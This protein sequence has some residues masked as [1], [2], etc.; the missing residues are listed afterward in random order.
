MTL[1]HNLRIFAYLPQNIVSNFSYYSFPKSV[2]A[3]LLGSLRS[4][5]Y[6]FFFV[7]STLKK[8]LRLCKII[9]PFKLILQ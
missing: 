9:L 8:S 6:K 3:P 2:F 7:V 5:N 4:Y 1:T